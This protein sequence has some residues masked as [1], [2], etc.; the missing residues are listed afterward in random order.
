MKMERMKFF[1]YEGKNSVLE[2]LRFF[3]MLKMGDVGG[4]LDN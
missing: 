4:M 1:C 2:L 3:A